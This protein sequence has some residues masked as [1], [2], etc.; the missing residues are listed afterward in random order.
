MPLKAPQ[1]CSH[2]ESAPSPRDSGKAMPIATDST[3]HKM[4]RPKKLTTQVFLQNRPM[5][6]LSCF[7]M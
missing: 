2:T 3:P 5:I 7:K 6:L 1:K 4:P